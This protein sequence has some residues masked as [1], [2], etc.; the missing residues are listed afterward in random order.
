M[1]DYLASGVPG[2]KIANRFRCLTERI[3]S[4]QRRRDLASFDELFDSDQVSGVDAGYA[5]EAQSTAARLRDP[6]CHEHVLGQTRQAGKSGQDTNTVW[7]QRAPI[8]PNRSV[9]NRIKD[10]VVT[11][12]GPREV[13]LSVIDDMPRAKRAHQ[14]QVAGTADTGDFGPS[15]PGDL[16]GK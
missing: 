4:V 9:A 15:G 10:Q 6:G 1:D 2:F 7:A 3:T 13:G 14:L 5:H 12:A 11:R 16:H 8:I